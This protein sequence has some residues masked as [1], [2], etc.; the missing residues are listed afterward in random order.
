M[1]LSNSNQKKNSKTIIHPETRNTH[2]I[3]SIPGRDTSNN[4]PSCRTANR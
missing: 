3:K 1:S 4:A 2:Y